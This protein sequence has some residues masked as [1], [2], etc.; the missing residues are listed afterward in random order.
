MEVTTR[1]GRTVKTPVQ[2]YEQN[3]VMNANKVAK[4]TK[5]I[6][7]CQLNLKR[8]HTHREKKKKTTA[9]KIISKKGKKKV[10]VKKNTK[11]N[12]KK[13]DVKKNTKKSRK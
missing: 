11:K 4:Y 13:V 6:R 5:K 8:V 10:D 3:C 7:D 2:K 1:S 12:T 9:A